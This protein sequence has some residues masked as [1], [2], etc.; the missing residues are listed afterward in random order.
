MIAKPSTPHLIDAACAE[1]T[2]K[3]APV[4]TDPTVKIALEMAIAVL[5]GASRRSA[6]ELAWMREESDAIE[7]VALR[8]VTELPAAT[9]L[10]DALADYTGG[11]SD[12]LYLADAQASYERASQ[13]LSAATEVVFTDGD[14]GRIAAVMALY[15][16]RI[17]NENAVTGVFVAAGRT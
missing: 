3:V 17:A 13:L 2:K 4:I 7:V 14:P 6:N 9:E 8:L 1:L 16:Q 5:Q 12:S 10:V 15:D 11:R